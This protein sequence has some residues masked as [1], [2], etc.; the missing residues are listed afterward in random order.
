M[1]EHRKEGKESSTTRRESNL[2]SFSLP[3]GLL[4]LQGERKV[5]KR[6]EGDWKLET[7]F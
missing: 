3:S 4:L 7:P 5:E 1:G 2:K 6:K